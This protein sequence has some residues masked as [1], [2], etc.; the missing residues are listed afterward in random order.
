MIDFEKYKEHIEYTFHAFCR[1]VIRNAAISAA[2][3]KYRKQQKEISLEYLMEEKYYQ[4]GI[5]DEYCKAPEQYEEYP[6]VICGD[7]LVLYNE[8]LVV[9]LSRLPAR[10]QEMVYL[11]FFKHIPQ[12]EIGRRYECSRTTAGYHICKA[13]RQLRTDIE[14]MTHEE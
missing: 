14:E 4:F 2:K 6:I 9:A 3:K 11:S 10:E 8:L 12:H 1:V 13:L 7:T 5:E